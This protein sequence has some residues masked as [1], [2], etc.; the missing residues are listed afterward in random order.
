MDRGPAEVLLGELPV[1]EL[2]EVGRDEV[3]ASVLEIQVVGVLPHVDREQAL[4]ALR[5]RRFGV[6]RL[7]HGELAA[8][9]DQRDRWDEK[10]GLQAR[11]LS[12]PINNELDWR[13]GGQ[14]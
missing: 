1:H 5:Q 14:P 7:D 13:N 2:V 11:Y 3:R 8:V 6:G 9:L 10:A 4:V 12:V